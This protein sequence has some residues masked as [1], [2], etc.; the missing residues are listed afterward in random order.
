MPVRPFKA[1]VSYQRYEHTNWIGLKFGYDTETRARLSADGPFR[2]DA[3]NTRGDWICEALAD[4][5]CDDP[6]GSR[7]S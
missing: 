4:S 1:S 7:K 6:L 5:S 2:V 3:A